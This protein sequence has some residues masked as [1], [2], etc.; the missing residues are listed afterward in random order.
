[1]LNKTVEGISG[2]I[3]LL[4]L[5]RHQTLIDAISLPPI[6]TL[7]DSRFKIVQ[8]DVQFKDQAP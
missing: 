7:C 2:V 1:M 6:L 5:K 4:Y 8:H 3:D